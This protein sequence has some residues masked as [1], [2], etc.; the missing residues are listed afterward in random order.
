MKRWWVMVSDLVLDRGCS[1]TDAERS[2]TALIPA[3]ALLA[4]T[5]VATCVGG[6]WPSG[7]TGQYAV[8][9]PP[10]FD[11]GRTVQL[12]AAADGAVVAVGGWSNVAVVRADSLW[13]LY[14][15]GA[16]L[17]LDPGKLRGC[18]GLPAQGGA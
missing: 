12:A 11:L 5:V 6:L 9:A 16:W 13:A 14:A 1:G 17:V 8:I 7:R 3:L 4:V 2:A 10:W 18:L 15:A